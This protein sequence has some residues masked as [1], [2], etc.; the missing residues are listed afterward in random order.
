[1]GADKVIINSL[2]HLK[3]EIIKLAVENFGSQFSM[4]KN[5]YFLVF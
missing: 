5:K 3:P 2:L 4:R 1:M